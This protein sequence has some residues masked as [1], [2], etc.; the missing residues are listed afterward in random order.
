[1][2]GLSKTVRT[3]QD[4]LAMLQRAGGDEAVRPAPRAS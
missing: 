3:V 2:S 1:M 4:D